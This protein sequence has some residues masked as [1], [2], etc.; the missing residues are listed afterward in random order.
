VILIGSAVLLAIGLLVLLVQAVSILVSL[1]KLAYYLAK[2]AV[3]LVVLVVCAVCL[4]VQYVLILARWLEGKP[5]AAEPE[6][7]ITINIYSNEEEDEDAPTIELPR[8]NFRR[9]RG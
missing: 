5:E 4:A 9:L 8:V 6:P 7:V 2:A 3:C 1:I